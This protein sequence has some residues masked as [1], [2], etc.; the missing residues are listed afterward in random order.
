MSL[1][2]WEPFRALR[3]RDE[4][5]EDLFRDFFRRADMADETMEPAVDVSESNGEVTVKCSVPGV[6]KDGLS[7]AV[8]H[9]MLTVRG[10]IRRESEEKKKNYYRQELRY[11]SFQRVV[12]LPVEVDA[13][14][15]TAELKDGILKV[16]LPKSKEAKTSEI[17]VRV[18]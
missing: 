1:I 9:D 15:A 4:A 14:K 6:D 13:A 11:G 3:R 2:R 7:V 10:E 16:T 12:P 8:N 17:K 18:A 5:F